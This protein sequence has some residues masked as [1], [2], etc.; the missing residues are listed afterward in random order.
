MTT[1]LMT[2]TSKTLHA[3]AED[4]ARTEIGRWELDIELEERS[5]ISLRRGLIDCIRRWR[6]DST[7]SGDRRTAERCSELLISLGEES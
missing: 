3:S 1:T 4:L 7:I 2:K 5:N 6:R